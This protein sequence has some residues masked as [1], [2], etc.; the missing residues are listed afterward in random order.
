[1]QAPT[2]QQ[3][4]VEI[5]AYAK[6]GDNIRVAVPQ[7]A[8][9]AA[10]PAV[11]ALGGLGSGRDD[12][13]EAAIRASIEESTPGSTPSSNPAVDM[14]T[15]EA[16]QM[17]FL[18]EQ[19]RTA[20]AQRQFSSTTVL[21]EYLVGGADAVPPAPAPAPVAR[22]PRAPTRGGPRTARPA[23]EAAEDA[24]LRAA[25]QASLRDVAKPADHKRGG[26]GGGGEGSAMDP[27]HTF[28]SLLINTLRGEVR[29]L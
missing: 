22:A 24:E 29:P 25:I 21:I 15:Q 27:A 20:Q 17:G 26:G 7:R 1:V 18:A 16:I 10:A 28:R 23:A 14:A 11:P 3:V 5:P 4:Q 9:P 2:G 12:D 8:A 13:L 6:P 19:V